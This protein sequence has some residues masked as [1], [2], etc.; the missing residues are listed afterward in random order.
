MIRLTAV[1]PGLLLATALA[2]S[3]RFLADVLGPWVSGLPISPIS[4]IMLAIV[5]GL[6]VRNLFRLP[7]AVDPGIRLGLSQVLK[8]GI[9]LLGIRLS[10]AEAG[11]IG[12]KALPVIVVCVTVALLTVTWLSRRLGLSGRL[13]TLIAAG[14]G[15]CGATAIVALSPAIRASDDETSYAVACVALFGVVAMLVYP[16]LSHALFAADPVLAGLFLGTAVHDTAQVAGA[17]LVYQQFWGDASALDT[18][19]V[20]KLVRNLGMVVVIPLLC[21]RHQRGEGERCRDGGKHDSLWS[22]VPL[23]VLGFAAMSLL[24]TVGDLGERPF[25]LLEPQQWGALVHGLTQVSGFCLGIAMASV[26]LGTS[27]AGL[28]QM[29]LKPLGVGL[30]SALLVGA[31]SYGM[32]VLLY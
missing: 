13:G 3:S 17:G 12:L 14:T 9:V 8:L 18:A 10:L 20:T 26:G 16:F 23:F 6:L 29:G 19:T 11:E 2:L 5:F 25:G 30:F 21:V 7:A 1:L 32:I 22:M 27:L 4:P 28:R 15:I 24:R 31:V